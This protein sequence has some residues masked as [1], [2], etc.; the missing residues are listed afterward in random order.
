MTAAAAKSGP[1]SG[2]RPASS[3]PQT[4]PAQPRSMAKSG[5]TS[6]RLPVAA[7]AITTPRRQA[8]VRGIF[9]GIKQEH[10]S[11][12]RFATIH[13]LCLFSYCA[14]KTGGNPMRWT[15]LAASAAIAATLSLPGQAA[16]PAAPVGAGG[17]PI[18]FGQYRDW[19]L[20]F[21]ERRQSDL[22]RQLAATDLPARQKARLEQVKAYY[23]WLAGL[24]AADRDRRFRARFDRMD[25]H[26]DGHLDPPN[27]PTR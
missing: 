25:A 7:C 4:A 10:I 22:A 24:P 1:D 2:P 3:M 14:T 18:T 17:D 26:P 13:I 5:M 27:P 9:L 20:A 11:L 16:Q 21:I 23:D 15:L 12:T 8:A 19:R 6:S